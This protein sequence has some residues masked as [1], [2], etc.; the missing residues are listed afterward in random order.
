MVV[1]V[2]G[3]AF[4]GC[5]RVPAPDLATTVSAGTVT[6]AGW[7]C[8]GDPPEAALPEAVTDVVVNKRAISAAK[9]S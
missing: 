2:A 9:C 8:A 3:M 6:E 5:L 1:S 4:L 7:V